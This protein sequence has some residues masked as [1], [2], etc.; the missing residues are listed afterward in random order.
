[1]PDFGAPVADQIQAP[2]PNQGMQTLSGMLGLAKANQSLQLGQ[3]Q[4]QV[5]Q[6]E[7]QQA[8][9]QMAERQLYQGALS[10]GKDPDGNSI[11]N[12]D[13]TLNYPAVSKFANKYMPL[14]GQAIQQ[15]IIS[16]LDNAN[17][18]HTNALKLTNNQR[19]AVSGVIASGIGE[20][21]TSGVTA[22]LTTLAQQNPD[23]APFVKSAQQAVNAIPPGANQDQRNQILRHAVQGL[24]PAGT[25]ANQQAPQMGTTTGPNGGVQAFNVNPNSATPMGAQ[26]PEVA[27]GVS[28][29]FA[30]QR[31]PVY[32]N[33]QAGTV[34]QGSLMNGGGSPFGSGRI[35]S[36]PGTNSS[37]V[38]SSAPIGTSEDVNWMKGD[39]QGVTAA[40][41]TAQQRVGLYNNVEQLS[42]QA[43]TGPQ[44]RLNYANSLL[45]LVGVPAAKDI[46]DAT[47]ALNKNASMIQQAFGGNTDAARAVVA[48]FTPGSVMPDKVNQEISEYGKANAQMQLFQQKYLKEASNGSDPGAYKNQK[49]DLAMVS[50]PRLWQ[51]QNASPADRVTMLRDMSPGQQQ[52][53][54]ALYKRANAMGAFQ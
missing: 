26:G 41:S 29:E 38:P 19:D 51:F 52:Q 20:P 11:K 40:A 3:Q 14:T 43:L 13:G 54:G 24:Q 50:D 4:L 23:L 28:P 47:V 49:A 39:Y 5:G 12:P 44:D 30:A 36:Q 31:V 21:D 22:R 34:S 25:T 2:N 46:N 32:Q 1:M 10:S 42:K 48:H 45:A 33:G 27:Q 37:F 7:A 9:Q 16:T 6:S 15:N 8:Q 18:Y 53:F 35:G 17:T